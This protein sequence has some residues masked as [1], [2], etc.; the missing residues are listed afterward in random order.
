MCDFGGKQMRVM[1]TLFRILWAFVLLSGIATADSPSAPP[2]APS[3]E[4]E[5]DGQHDMDFNIGSWKAQIKVLRASSAGLATWAELDGTAIVRK[6]WNGRAQLEEVEAD[7]SRGHFEALVLLLYNPGAHQWSKSFANS[8]DG[9]LSSP[10]IGEFQNGRGELFNQETFH[11]K[12][13]LMRA[14][15]SD[16][17]ASSQHF[18][19]SVS[20]D[21]GRSWQPYFIA[22]FTRTSQ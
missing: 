3:A 18:E 5:R 4:P 6:V 19:E 15:W 9:Q 17:T 22:L 7:G 16:I 12:T 13:A 14:V 10:M 11:G 1:T 21:G 8:Q 20:C 2:S